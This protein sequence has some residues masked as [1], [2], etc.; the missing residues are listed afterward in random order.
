[1]RGASKPGRPRSSRRRA[2]TRHRARVHLCRQGVRARAHAPAGDEPRARGAPAALRAHG[3]RS[4]SRW[5]HERGRRRRA[6]TRGGWRCL[7]PDQFSNPA[8][9]AAH[10]A[11]TG[12]EL[13]E[14]LDGKID[15]LVCGVGTGGTITGTGRYL[16]ARLPKLHIVAGG[17]GVVAS[18]VGGKA[19]R[20][21]SRASAL[22]SSRRC[23]SAS[24]STR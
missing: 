8:N 5:R 24:S 17:A 11:S 6:Q 2:A 23:S 4:S 19:D 12:P 18:A 10:E 9:P 21:A 15:V 1:M 3:S 22:G 16:K 20:T 7:L 13:F 14:Q